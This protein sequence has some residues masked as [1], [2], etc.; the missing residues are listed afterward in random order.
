MPRRDEQPI[1]LAAEMA[2]KI[3]FGRGR[4]LASIASSRLFEPVVREIVEMA[5]ITEDDNVVVL[6][7][8]D[9]RLVPWVAPRCRQLMFVD[10]LPD[11]DLARME[12]AQHG[13]GH[14]NVKFQWGRANVIPTPQYT[15]DRVIALNY[16]YRAR[17]PFA[18][19]RQMHVTS[20]HG[21][22]VVCCEPSASLDSRTARKYSREAAL[23]MDEHR[24]LVAYARSVA[25]HRGFTRE[26]MK[27]LLTKAGLQEIELRELLHGLVIAARGKVRL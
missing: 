5:G 22:T 27:G 13:A 21:S 11:D 16:L 15:T 6:G 2:A 7:S 20:R 17:H 14:G 19:V 26:G 25:A 1:G 23:E 12:T 10:D 9:L 18:V 3:R 24:A 4:G 8:A